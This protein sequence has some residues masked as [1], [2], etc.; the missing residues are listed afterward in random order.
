MGKPDRYTLVA[1][2]FPELAK[3]K[4]SK[5]DRRAAIEINTRACEAILGDFIGLFDKG[6]SS[7]GP[8]VLSVRLSNDKTKTSDYV[9]LAELA[10][11]VDLARKDGDEGMTS[12]MES[13]VTAVE[14]LNANKAALLLLVDYE[15]FRLLPV[16]RDS[17]AATITAVMEEINA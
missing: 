7:Y 8:G 5:G 11:D 10:A 1:K 13:V 14:E 3:P 12:A 4:G 6:Y 15:G 2:M 9:T 17:P 16:D